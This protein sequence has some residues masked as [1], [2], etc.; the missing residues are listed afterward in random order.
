[1][2]HARRRCGRSCLGPGFESPRLHEKVVLRDS[3]PFERAAPFRLYIGENDSPP[4]LTGRYH[5][6]TIGD[7]RGGTKAFSAGGKMGGGIRPITNRLSDRAIKAFLAQARAGT[8]AKKKLFDGGGLYLTLTPA[9]TAV[10]RLKYRIGGRERLVAAGVHPEVSLADARAKRDTIRAQL[11]DGVDPIVARV[12]RDASATTFA[13]VAAQWLETRKGDW[14]GIHFEKTQQAF[15]RDVLPKLGNLRVSDIT[16]AVIA[17]VIEAIVKRGSLETASK[18]LQNVGAVFRFA[19]GKGFSRGGS[20]PAAAVREL[21]PRKRSHSQ[22]PALLK[23]DA[24]A[25]LLRRAEGAP[26]SPAVRICHRLIAYT[27]ARIGNAITADWRE[28]DLDSETPTWT[29]PRSRM[30]A[31]DRPFDHKVILA[32]T[33]AKELRIWRSITG[34]KGLV[35]PSPTGRAHIT[36]E[37]LEKAL[38]VTLGM[39]G[40]H[41]VHGW[42]ASFS[43]LARDHGFSREVTELTLDHLHDNAVARAYDRG[44]RLA[45]RVKLMYWWD[46]ELSACER[47]TEPTHR[48]DVAGR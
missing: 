16:P 42:R 34:G 44:E 7:I 1:M 33:I 22:R 28:F 45:E 39:E 32:P 46:A 43:T 13:E 20:N 29:I 47:E 8:A 36:H 48:H 40:K 26:I 15:N 12:N 3:A 23:F 2:E 25:D 17:P 18:V 14:S 19:E 41:S 10:W 11:R 4:F 35:F 5:P 24:L 6:P 21:L 30:K 37:A 27:A 9:G 38:R 31:K